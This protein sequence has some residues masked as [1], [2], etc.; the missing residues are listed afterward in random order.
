MGV[1]NTYL[2][3]KILMC[4]DEHAKAQE[5]LSAQFGASDT[6]AGAPSA[7]PAAAAAAATGARE[8]PSAPPAS[9]LS[10]PA[11]P[12]PAPSAPPPVETYQST[13]CVVCLENKVR[14]VNWNEQ[15]SVFPEKLFFSH[16][17][18]VLSF[19]RSATSSFSRAATSASASAATRVSPSVPSVGPTSARRSDCDEGGDFGRGGAAFQIVEGSYTKKKRERL[20][21]NIRGT[22]SSHCFFKAFFFQG[23]INPIYRRTKKK[24]KKVPETTHTHTHT[25]QFFQINKRK[26]KLCRIGFFFHK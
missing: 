5:R 10:E 2:R 25:H 12:A 7:P 22:K 17:V 24:R 11:E 1:H 6:G 8:V 9:K 20:L 15:A 16:N 13:E 21:Q 23:S 19:A 4:A 26:R 14:L 18:L 3:Q